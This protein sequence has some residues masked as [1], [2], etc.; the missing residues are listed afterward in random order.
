M[1]KQ[2]QSTSGSRKKRLITAAIIIV[3]VLAAV[4]GSVVIRKNGDSSKS[5]QPTTAQ[6]KAAAKVDLEAKRALIE[7]SP[8]KTTT[9]TPTTVAPATNT[10]PPI[11][12]TAKT[13]SNNSVTVIGK[14]TNVSNGTCLLDV[15]NGSAVFTAKADVIYEPEYSSCAG[16]SVPIAS[17]GRGTWTIKLT[18]N[19]GTAQSTKT[20]IYNVQ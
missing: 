8:S 7:S 12:L 5:N 13:E 20:I 3:L 6:R 15:T 16:F 11:D 9:T 19:P 17:L 1:Y 14:F 2:D 18:V 4:I 10:P